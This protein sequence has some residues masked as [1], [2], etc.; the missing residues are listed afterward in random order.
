MTSNNTQYQTRKIGS[1]KGKPRVWLEGAILTDNGI[2]HGMRFD[3]INY[4]QML[5]IVINPQGARKIAGKPDRPII[6]MS[7]ATITASFDDSIKTVT[8]KPTNTGL[9]LIGVK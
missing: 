5:E 8:V 7:A 9:L 6:D 4:P 1:N 3:V 2:N